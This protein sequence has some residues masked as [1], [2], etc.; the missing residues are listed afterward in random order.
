M[1]AWAVP[2]CEDDPVMFRVEEEELE[3]EE[4]EDSKQRSRTKKRG[5]K[6]FIR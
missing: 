1:C 6:R 5:L 4:E 2:V 3:E